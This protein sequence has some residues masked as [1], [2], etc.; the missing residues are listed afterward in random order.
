MRLILTALV[1]L[2]IVGG[3]SLYIRQRDA[4]L[5]APAKAHIAARVQGENYA[6]EITPTFGAEADPFALQDEG[7]KPSTLLVRLG[8]LDIFRQ[9]QP[10][11]RGE[12]LRIAPLEGLLA[13]QNELFFEASPSF[14]ESHLAHAL[15]VQLLRDGV[16]LFDRTLW[17]EAGAKVTGSLDFLLQQP[18]EAPHDH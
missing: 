11:A 2:L 3:L 15:R 10:L 13:G 14:E 5:V 1:W 7:P 6:L 8:G 17:S 4:H 18:A 9:D 12:T 16:E